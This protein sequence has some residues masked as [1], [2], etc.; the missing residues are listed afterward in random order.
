MWHP[1]SSFKMSP[2]SDPFFVMILKSNFLIPSQA[3]L[4][5]I[6]LSRLSSTFP[7]NLMKEGAPHFIPERR[8]CSH[9]QSRIY[10]SFLLVPQTSLSQRLWLF[11]PD[12]GLNLPFCSSIGQEQHGAGKLDCARI[13]FPLYGSFDIQV[14]LMNCW[15]V[16][17]KERLYSLMLHNFSNAYGLNGREQCLNSTLETFS[18]PE[19]A[20]YCHLQAFP[21]A[22]WHFFPSLNQLELKPQG[23]MLMNAR[24]F[25]EM[26]GKWHFFFLLGGEE[27]M[28]LLTC[29][30]F[31]FCSSTDRIRRKGKHKE[32]SWNSQWCLNIGWKYTMWTRKT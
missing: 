26:S 20:R 25:L 5:K 12:Y 22:D 30:W 32:L 3:S 16:I 29:N 2:C 17:I 11:C 31:Y 14:K 23:R 27:G 15:G 24:Y 28:S 8:G 4:I 13:L 18:I 1:A 10:L 21:H 6:P 19:F 7:E 9:P